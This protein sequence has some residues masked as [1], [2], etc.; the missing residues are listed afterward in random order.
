MQ[1]SNINYAVIDDDDVSI[2]VIKFK[3]QETVLYSNY[4]G[5]GCTIEEGMKLLNE[6]EPDLVFLDIVLLD[7]TGFD[8]IDKVDYKDFEIIIISS[9]HDF[10]VAAYDYDALD[11]LIKPISDEKFERA[12]NKYFK[13]I[14]VSEDNK[15]D[16]MNKPEKIAVSCRNGV[17]FLSPEEIIYLEGNDNYT[18]IHLLDKTKITVSKTLKIFEKKLCSYEFIRVHNKHI[19][20][21][22]FIRKLSN[23]TIMLVN[24]SEISISNKYRKIFNEK[25]KDIVQRV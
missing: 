23:N 25:L 4:L 22:K 24:G 14:R 19:I 5:S 10:G 11:Y 6:T 7:G 18:D 1:N 17:E 16:L 8:I 12:I 9:Y 15:T 3:M 13:K 20:N 2:S 21:L